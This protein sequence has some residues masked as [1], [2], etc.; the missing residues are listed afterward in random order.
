[1][2]FMVHYYLTSIAKTR[3]EETGFKHVPEDVRFAR[4]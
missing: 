3:Y 4:G 2:D 1:M